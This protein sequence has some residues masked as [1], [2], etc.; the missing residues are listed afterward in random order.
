MNCT[1]FKAVMRPGNTTDLTSQCNRCVG[2]NEWRSVPQNQKV[3]HVDLIKRL[4]NNVGNLVGITLSLLLVLFFL[5]GLY[6]LSIIIAPKQSTAPK[7]TTL[8]GDVKALVIQG[9]V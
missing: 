6:K 9:S 5:L 3:F 7:P 1:T 4:S 2:N 8:V